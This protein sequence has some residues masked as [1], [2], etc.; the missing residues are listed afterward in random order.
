[1]KIDRFEFFYVVLPSRKPFVTA[2]CTVLDRELIVVKALSSDGLVGWGEV[3]ADP[4]PGYAPETLGS[5]RY[6]IDRYL[7]PAL[8]GREIAEPDDAP[9]AWSAFVGNE[10]AKSGLEL[11]VWDLLARERGVSVAGMLGATGQSVP[12]GVSVGIAPGIDEFL[13]E[14]DE[15]LA[16]G[17]R[18]VKVKIRPGWDVEP[19]RAVRERFG[20]VRLQADAN[21]AY[22]TRD[23]DHLARLDEFGLEMLEQPLYHDDLADHA[24]LQS[25]M[26]TP[27]CLDESIHSA[28]HARVAAE[29][30][31]CRVVNVKVSRVGGLVEARRIVDVCHEGG[32]GAWCG[33]MLESGVGAAYNLAFA[34]SPGV[35]NPGDVIPPLRYFE[36]DIIRPAMEMAS[37]GTVTLPE[38]VGL[39]FEVDEDEL[40]ALTRERWTIE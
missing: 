2:T 39:G 21:S 38:G 5:A 12:I 13:A 34:L 11:A 19:L 28:R 33:S 17:Y 14:V 8:I 15:A 25:K 7:A 35:T 30:G 18:R 16:A 6:V 3:D 1:L 20:D 24:K 40:E 23:F 31:S 37:D 26:E 32:L 4:D 36:R 27:L 10:M 22:G 29:L 9:R